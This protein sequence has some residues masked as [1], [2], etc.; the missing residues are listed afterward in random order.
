M[1]GHQEGVAGGLRP[2]LPRVDLQAARLRLPRRRRAAVPGHHL[3]VPGQARTSPIP[4]RSRCPAVLVTVVAS[5]QLLKWDDAGRRR[6]ARHGRPQG[7]RHRR[8]VLRRARLLRLAALDRVA[9]SSWCSAPPRSSY[10]AATRL[11]GRPPAVALLS[12]A[13]SPSSPTTRSSDFEQRTDHSLGAYSAPCSA[14]CVIAVASVRVGAST[15]G[16]RCS[17]SPSTELWPGGPGLPL[18]GAGHRGRRCWRCS[19][20]GLVLPARPQHQLPRHGH[21]VRRHQRSVHDGAHRRVLLL[22]RLG[23]AR[24][25][26]RCCRARRRLRCA[27]LGAAVAAG[28]GARRRRA[29]PGHAVRHQ[30]GRRRARRRRCAT[31]PWQNL[32]AGGWLACMGFS[33]MAARLLR[34][35]HGLRDAASGARM[36]RSR[37][38]AA[39]LRHVAAVSRILAGA[40]CSSVS[41]W[42]CSSRRR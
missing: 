35:G 14:S 6:Q 40:C 31:G 2:R 8:A 28:A 18:A 10:D 24:R 4:A 21:A 19:P 20:R 23:A 11:P 42:R 7:R 9:S 39:R 22:A 12:R 3:L 41:P 37:S 5:Y 13:S 25:G 34:R 38:D 15:R 29:H 17:A 33:L 27:Q 30:Q 36:A 26:H 32:G 16:R 1:I